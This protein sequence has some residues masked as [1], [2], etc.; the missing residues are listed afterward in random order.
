MGKSSSCFR[1][2]TCGGDE[3]EKDDH[4]V[5]S[6]INDS[7]DKRGWSFRKRSAR[8]R[9]LS[10]TAITETPSSANKES[11]ERTSINFQSVAEPNVVEKIYTTNFSDEKPQLSSLASSQVSETIVTETEGK[12][13][14]NQPESVVI[15]IQAAIRRFLAQKALLKSKNV[16]K[17]QAA[18]R[19]HLVRKHAVGTLRCVQAIVKMQLLVR[20]RHAKQSH[21]ENHLNHK[22]GKND[23]S[24]T[25]GT[26]YHVTKSNV[27]H[28]SIEKLLSNRFARQLLESTPKNKPINVK[29]DPSKA[30]SAWK[31]LERWMSVSSKDSAEYKKPICVSEQSN[32]T[33]DS[34][35]VSQLETDIQSEVFLQ[36]AD[37]KPTV[38]D[39]S[40]P[41][42]NEEKTTTYDANNFNFQASPSTKDNLEQTPHEKTITDDAKVT[43]TE[44]DSFQN[45]K[46]ESDTIPLQEPTSFPHKP[47][48]DDEQCKQSIKT[49]AS[50]QLET[51]GMTFAHESRKFSNPAFIAAHSKFEELSL[52]AN[53][54]R[55]SSMSNQV[56]SVEL[57]ADTTSVV[58]DTAYRSKEFLSSENSTPYPSR[59]GGSECGT[60]L[61]IS[62]TLDSPD[63]LEVGIMENEH[64]A[65]DL[66]EG[67]GNP[68]N[69]I[70]HGVEVNILCATPTSN[71]PCSDLDQLEIVDDI[72]G[73]MVH[74]VV[75][76]DSKE[77]AVETEKNASDLLREQAETVLQDFKLSPEASPGSHMTIPESQG[78]PSSQVS[79]KPKES[80]TKKTGSSNRRRILS[81]GN[82]SPANAN[83][84]SG[85]SGSREQLPKDQ[86][87]GK[88]RNSFGSA[89]LDHVDQEPRDNSSDNSSIP[90]F[91]QATE[92]A[93][94]KINAN[95]S[96]RSSPDVHDQETHVKKRH[97]LPGATGRQG[98]P[99]IQQ[100]S[101][102]QPSTKGN[103]VHAL[104][105]RKW[106]R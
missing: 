14:V 49:V 96:P 86:Q 3:A 82:K 21:S 32:E 1:L 17:L 54:D 10:N 72:S 47:E 103:G 20:A 52:M 56:A 18:V 74:S 77:P 23:G 35:Y 106:Q 39:S 16:V 84:D 22:D 7:N 87:S 62:S 98:S 100:S 66:V 5:V 65:K 58:T 28:N 40:L 90:H 97:S 53:S 81:A 78:T 71:L 31:W 48:I 80:K 42:E 75:L 27:T 99:R 92:S 44:I 33:K 8:H 85:S 24:K 104:N 13:D 4:Q 26:E 68:E 89:K 79:V 19:G 36:F 83:H 63:R 73:K 88:R 64:D 15:I 9:V 60:E 30:N 91:M 6:E 12:V 70:D 25:L 38:G 61:S 93:R 34:T 95:N 102:A 43:S 2:I 50:D 67:I 45:E 55:S 29:C 57:Q 76:G 41:S 69:K 11:S 94:A 37:S 101:Q 59:I 51:E 46:M 105:E